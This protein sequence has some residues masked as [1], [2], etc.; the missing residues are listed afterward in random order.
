MKNRNFS[1]YFASTDFD[2]LLIH[3]LLTKKMMVRVQKA[4]QQNDA[5]IDEEKMKLPTYVH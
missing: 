3:G 4:W 5:I 1:A 2:A